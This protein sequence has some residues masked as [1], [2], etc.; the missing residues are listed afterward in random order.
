M[1]DLHQSFNIAQLIL[2]SFRESLTDS[3]SEELDSWLSASPRNRKSYELWKQSDLTEKKNLI[4][5]L[6]PESSWQQLEN[7]LHFKKRPIYFRVLKYVAAALIIITAGILI[8]NR[9]SQDSTPLLAETS[10]PVPGTAKAILILE[11]GKQME[12][13]NGQNF[14]LHKDSSIQ[15]NNNN[16]ILKVEVSGFR[17]DLPENYST[18]SVPKGGE[19]QLVLCD[20]S[21]IWLNSDSRLRFPDRFGGDQRVVYL[22]GEAYFEV[23][24]NARKP[25]IVSV[26][27]MKVEVLGTKFDIKAYK[28]DGIIYTTLLSGSVKT[29][30]LHSGQSVILH[31]NEQCL[32]DTTRHLLQKR[33]VDAAT[34]IGWKEGRFIFE[35]E[36]LEEIMKQLSRWYNVE[37]T[38][39]SPELANYRFTGNT[40]RFDQISSLLRMIE[41]TYPISFSINGN[42]IKVTKRASCSRHPAIIAK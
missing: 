5:Q 11:S 7:K 40:G 9:F 33:T 29:S 25:F 8:H 10:N 34:F 21:K 31:P 3:E 35:N 27:N 39:Q 19:Y 4:N 32:F 42:S 30:N 12:L 15:I 17:K 26:R 1:E 36:P 24:H 23:A 20:G 18:L 14:Y 16:N 38:Y 13:I 28:E 2:K 6:H 22:E 41:K 37:V